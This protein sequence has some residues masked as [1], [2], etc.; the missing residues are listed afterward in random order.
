MVVFIDGF[1]SNRFL[2]S[3]VYDSCLLAFTAG[4]LRVASCQ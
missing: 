4:C 1:S 3:R 2:Q